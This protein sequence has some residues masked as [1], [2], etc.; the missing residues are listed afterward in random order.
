MSANSDVRLQTGQVVIDAWDLCLDSPDRRNPAYPTPYR[1]A[2]VHDPNDGL[3]LNWGQDYP[4]GVT[5]NGVVSVP[6]Q[7]EVRGSSRLEGG[8][9]VFG[10]TRLEGKLEVRKLLIN[11]TTTI[12]GP[13]HV[14]IPITIQIDVASEIAALK[15][16][17]TALEKRLGKFQA[18]WRWCNKCQGLFFAGGATKGVCPKGGEHSLDGS[19]DYHL[20][21]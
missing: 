7:L 3:T 19:G 16:K 8:V 9:E 15:E 18:N 17:V 10:D 1:R 5:I 12:I 11:F 6:Q 2:L 20:L 14:P 13:Q 4:G 21:F